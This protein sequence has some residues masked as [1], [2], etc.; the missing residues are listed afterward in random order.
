[1]DTVR[2]EIIINLFNKGKEHLENSDLILLEANPDIK[3]ELME[4]FKMEASVDPTEITEAKNKVFE[5]LMASIEINDTGSFESD[6]IIEL[7]YNDDLLVPVMTTL[8]PPDQ[9]AVLSPQS[10]GTL[11]FELK[12]KDWSFILS[13]MQKNDVIEFLINSDKE[14][15]NFCLSGPTKELN[16]SLDEGETN[17]LVKAPD[18][19]KFKLSGDDTKIV[20]ISIPEKK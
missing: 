15:G 12:Q 9:V 16:S 3:A 1:M 11:S 13:I 8:P 4:L 19:G 14:E 5:K 18:G 17:F 20:T 6:L 10:S 7:E 2:D